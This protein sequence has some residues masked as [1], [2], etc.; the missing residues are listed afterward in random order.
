MKVILPQSAKLYKV[1]DALFESGVRLP[2]RFWVIFKSLMHREFSVSR[3]AEDAGLPA[4]EVAS[5]LL[6]LQRKELLVDCTPV[7]EFDESLV[8]DEEIIRPVEESATGAQ[9]Q[10]GS[11]LNEVAKGQVSMVSSND[12]TIDVVV[13]EEEEV[14]I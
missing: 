12:A 7:V 2:Q 11:S 6:E 14:E 1:A 10:A 3:F 5:F 4:Y 9:A 8:E 13:S